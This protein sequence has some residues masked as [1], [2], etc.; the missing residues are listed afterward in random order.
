MESTGVTGITSRLNSR[1][2]LPL[3]LFILSGCSYSDGGFFY[4]VDGRAIDPGGSPLSQ[5]AIMAYFESFKVNTESERGAVRT[6]DDGSFSVR[7][8]TGLA[9][10]CTRLFGLVPFGPTNGPKPPRLE[11]LYFAVQEPAGTWQYVEVGLTREQQ[12]KAAPAERW[13]KVGDVRVLSR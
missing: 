8:G 13:I 3:V 12:S 1:C 2:V 11:S 10:G 5:R 7:F 4:H 9:W 6:G